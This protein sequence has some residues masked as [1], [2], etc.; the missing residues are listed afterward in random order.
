MQALDHVVKYMGEMKT[1]LFGDPATDKAP[2][3]EDGKLLAQ[4][5][6]KSKLLT[7]MCMQLAPLGFEARYVRARCTRCP[8]L[9]RKPLRIA[10]AGAQ[11]RG[12]GILRPA[13]AHKRRPAAVHRIPGEAHRAPRRAD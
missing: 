2:K 8:P 10:R 11:G 4:E 13:T 3:D 7:H 1:M 9:T 5:A 6:A 12:A